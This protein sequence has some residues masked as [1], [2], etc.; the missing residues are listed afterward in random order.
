MAR[1]WLAFLGAACVAT[2]AA[3]SYGDQQRFLDLDGTDWHKYVR[4][5]SDKNILPARVLS[6]YAAGN[7]TSAGSLAH[8]AVV[9]A[10]GPTV[11]TRL[12][13]SDDIP[14]VV[15]DFG[16]NTV[17]L[18][19]IDFDGSYNIS[20]GFPGIT[21]AFSETLQYLTDR[22]DFTRSDNAGGVSICQR[23]SIFLYRS[24]GDDLY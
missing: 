21:L 5:P 7:V 24:R 10:Q 2:G 20:T 14:T 8:P 12:A 11:L 13:A 9:S 22:S 18:L 1:F 16:Q 4:A 17:G 15:L 19:T 6:A 3:E 23:E